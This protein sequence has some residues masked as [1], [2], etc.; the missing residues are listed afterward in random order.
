MFSLF[1]RKKQVELR[2]GGAVVKSLPPLSG[3]PAEHEFVAIPRHDIPELAESYFRAM[4]TE[5]SAAWCKCLWR[6]HPDDQGIKPGTCRECG[7]TAASGV[8]SGKSKPEYNHAFRGIRR[9]KVDDHPECPVHTKEGMLIY[10]FEWVFSG[11]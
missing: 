9:A 2:E 7:A 5:E 11:Q 3:E 1:G 8:H 10:F 6:I 4:E